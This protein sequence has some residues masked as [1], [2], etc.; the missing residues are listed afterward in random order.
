MQGLDIETTA[1]DPAEGKVGLV[2]IRN[3]RRGRVYD[4]HDPQVIAELLRLDKPVAHNATFERA[5]STLREQL[6]RA[7]EGG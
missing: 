5:E 2:Q 6:E 4:G 1:L 3:G 7:G